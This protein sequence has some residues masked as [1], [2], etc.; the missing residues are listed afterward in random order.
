MGL[1]SQKL[2]L[3]VGAIV[4]LLRNLNVQMRLSNSTGLKIREM[5]KHIMNFK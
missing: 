1:P 4:M 2:N 5:S 3:K